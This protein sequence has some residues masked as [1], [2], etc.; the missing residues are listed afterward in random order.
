M[1]KL[2][3]LSGTDQSMRY[4]L[5]RPSQFRST[6]PQRHRCPTFLLSSMNRCDMKLCCVPSPSVLQCKVSDRSGSK[7]RDLRSSRCMIILQDDTM[8]KEH[9]ELLE[10][11]DEYQMHKRL[12]CKSIADNDT[13]SECRAEGIFST[14]LIAYIHIR[15][16]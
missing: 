3:R 8:R 10:N 16:F 12:T 7:L 4:H 1:L 2:A 15:V 9:D 11:V 14:F 5:R 13:Q 6:M